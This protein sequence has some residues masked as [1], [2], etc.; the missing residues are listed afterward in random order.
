MPIS[1]EPPPIEELAAAMRDRAWLDMRVVGGGELVRVMPVNLSIWPDRD[2]VTVEQEYLQRGDFQK[3]QVTVD[4]EDIMWSRPTI[5]GISDVE[6]PELP[7]CEDQPPTDELASHILDTLAFLH[8]V[9]PKQVKEGLPAQARKVCVRLMWELTHLPQSKIP[10]HFGY[11]RGAQ[12][13][14]TLNDTQRPELIAEVKR[15]H[16]LLEQR[17]GRKLPPFPRTS[18]PRGRKRVL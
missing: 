1:L 11:Q 9:T 8:G 16:E 15:A 10:H 5:C 12:T 13:T 14:Y 17:M 7:E 18:V 4:A 2:E 3:R 6:I